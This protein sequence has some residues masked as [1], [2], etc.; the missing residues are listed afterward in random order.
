MGARSCNI[1][2]E[3]PGIR[4]FRRDRVYEGN[5]G[6]SYEVDELAG[7]ASIV[8]TA[9]VQDGVLSTSMEGAWSEHR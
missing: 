5:D 6:R 7:I 9:Q 8:A 1:T 3:M 4:G 2:S